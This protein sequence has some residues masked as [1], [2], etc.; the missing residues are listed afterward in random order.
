[1]IAVVCRILGV[2]WLERVLCRIT[3]VVR[4]VV[5]L[6]HRNCSGVV[7]AVDRIVS[8]IRLETVLG[9]LSSRVYVRLKGI[10]SLISSRVSGETRLID[11]V[12]WLVGLVETR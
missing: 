4:I 5:V 10:P 2:M 3:C 6:V 1:M 7:A 11:V 12:W 9:G 8:W